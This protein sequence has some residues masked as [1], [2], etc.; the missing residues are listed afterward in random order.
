MVVLSAGDNALERCS[1]TR[2]IITSGLG[3]G[4]KKRRPVNTPPR[5]TLTPID[6]TRRPISSQRDQFIRPVTELVTCQIHW[7][8]RNLGRVRADRNARSRRCSAPGRPLRPPPRPERGPP[9]RPPPRPVAPTSPAR[10]GSAPRRAAAA[11]RRAGAGPPSP[12][13]P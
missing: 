10:T 8:G 7:R 6:T 2:E 13:Q 4:R 5:K 11:P 3:G 12:T 9:I 1:T